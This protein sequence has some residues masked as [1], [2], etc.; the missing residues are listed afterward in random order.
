LASERTLCGF[1]FDGTLAPIVQHP[2]EAEMR[3]RTREVLRELA[4][5]FPC[6]I[7]SGR[8]GPDVAAKVGDICVARVLG[9]HGAEI[10][11]EAFKIKPEVERW[12]A[13][14]DQKLNGSQGVWIENKG[15][16]LAVH[17][18]QAS[19][20]PEM[21]RRILAAAREIRPARVFSGKQVINLTV[22]NA[23]H[24]GLALASERKRLGCDWVLFVGDDENDED[25]FSIG[26]NIIATR[27]GRK[28]DS[29]AE[30]YLKNQSEI[31]TLLER[32][33]KLR[34]PAGLC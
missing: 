24:K 23:P 31:D 14:L 15:L 20:K 30:Y 5:A 6:V 11:P 16:S 13:E 4:A 19:D 17:Y 27:V 18:R 26:G 10:A 34:A 8:A 25:A 28:R 9:N 12:Q 1:D 21:R 2:N 32:L 33:V 22:K 3:P 7:L 29:Q